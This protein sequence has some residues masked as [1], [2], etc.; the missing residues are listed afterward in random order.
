VIQGCHGCQPSVNMSP[1]PLILHCIHTLYILHM[2]L[3]WWLDTTVTWC[4]LVSLCTAQHSWLLCVLHVCTYLG[5]YVRMLTSL[6]LAMLLAAWSPT[7]WLA[8]SHNALSIFTSSQVGRLPWNYVCMLRRLSAL[9]FAASSPGQQGMLKLP[10]IQPMYI[11]I[12]ICISGTC[13]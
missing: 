13:M 12:D 1:T 8:H 10:C 11:C 7:S 9:C 5:M 4:Q 2:F 3:H 6:L